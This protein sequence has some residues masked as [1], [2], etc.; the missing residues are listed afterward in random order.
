MFISELI[1]ITFFLILSDLTK[2]SI[3]MQISLL[4]FGTNW[5][6]LSALIN[7]NVLSKISELIFSIFFSVLLDLTWV[8]QRKYHC[9]LLIQK[10]HIC[11]HWYWVLSV[12][13]FHI[14]SLLIFGL[15]WSDLLPLT[16]L[17]VL[18]Q[19]SELIF[20]AFFSVPSDLTK[21]SILMQISL[22]TFG[23]NWSDLLELINLN[24]LSQIF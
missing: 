18:S 21:M 23:I 4:T 14:I 13:F 5:W 9:W 11:Q 19:I 10:D 7:L 2:M 24:V 3:L 1:F 15:Y 22:V 12:Q 20:N 17:N 8:F 16:N 6:D